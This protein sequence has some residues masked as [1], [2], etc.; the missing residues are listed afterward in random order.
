M[1]AR[2]TAFT[3]RRMVGWGLDDGARSVRIAPP[4]PARA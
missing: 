1:D 2:I 4:T 3:T